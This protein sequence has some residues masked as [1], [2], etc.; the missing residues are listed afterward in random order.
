MRHEEIEKQNQAVKDVLK[1]VTVPEFW[2]EVG[3]ELS[4][5]LESVA[6]YIFSKGVEYGMLKMLNEIDKLK[7]PAPGGSE[8]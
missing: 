6:R 1:Q 5:Q 4:K 8:T 3:P 7:P 2:T